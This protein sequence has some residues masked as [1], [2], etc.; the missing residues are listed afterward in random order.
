MP[1]GPCTGSLGEAVCA[2]EVEVFSVDD[3][4]RAVR[5]L[6]ADAG[7]AGEGGTSAGH[8]AVAFELCPSPPPYD[9]SDPSTGGSAGFPT[10]VLVSPEQTVSVRTSSSEMCGDAD[11]FSATASATGQLAL[12]TG[13]Y[14]EV[15][16]PAHEARCLYRAA[17]PMPELCAD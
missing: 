7:R 15:L 13:N 4:V 1:Q 2:G 9:P 12:E 16:V 8:V 5:W 17:A 10:L 14:T 6:E 11:V 3:Y